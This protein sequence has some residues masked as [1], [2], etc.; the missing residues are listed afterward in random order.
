MERNRWVIIIAAFAFAALVGYVAY[1]AGISAGAAQSGKVVAAPHPYPAYGYAYGWR[2]P[3]FGPFIYVVLLLV[4]TRLLVGGRF[5]CRHHYY[6]DLD[7]WHR[8]AHEQSHGG[9]SRP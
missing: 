4:I 9:T 1:N 5:R 2:P 3:F 7:D 6:S 8:R